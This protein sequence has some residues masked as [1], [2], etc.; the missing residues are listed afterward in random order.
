MSAHEGRVDRDG[1]VGGGPVPRWRASDTAWRG[2]AGTG[3]TA[4]VALALLVLGSVFV[5]VAA[6]RLDLTMRS[7]AL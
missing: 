4:T 3:A 2:I 1:E 5:A 6:P 7:R